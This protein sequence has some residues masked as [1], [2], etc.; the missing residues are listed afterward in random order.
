M[1]DKEYGKEYGK[2]YGK[3]FLRARERRRMSQEAVARMV[4]VGRSQ[5][6]HIEAGTS[7]A[8]L[9][10]FMGLCVQLRVDP[11]QAYFGFEE[12]AK[13]NLRNAQSIHAEVR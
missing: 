9:P 10:V 5:I 13:I 4:G 8:S 2:G 11:L 6:A 3:R 7:E 12:A 1:Q